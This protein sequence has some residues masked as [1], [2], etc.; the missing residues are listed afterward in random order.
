[1]DLLSV[2]LVSI[3]EELL[4]G[5]TT[6]TNASWLARRL[7]EVGVNVS[8]VSVCGDVRGQMVDAISAAARRAPVVVCTGG[9]G[10]TEDDRTRFAI[11]EIAGVELQPHDD[12]VEHIKRI[13]ARFGRTMPARNTVQAMIPKGA[14]VL[15]NARGTAPGFA[16]EVEGTL[17]ACLP[18]VPHEMMAMAE[19]H[20]LPMIARR[21]GAGRVRRS[22]HLHC[23]GPGESSVNEKIADLMPPGPDPVVGLAVDAG[24]ITVRITVQGAPDEVESTLD[25]L[26]ARVVE[27]L[28]DWIYGRGG[29]SLQAVVGGM[30]IGAGKTIALAESCTAGL[31][32]SRLGEVPGISVSLLECVVTY[33][34]DAKIRRLGVDPKLIEVHGA[35]SGEVAAAMAEGVRKTSGADLGLSVTGIAGPTGGSEEKPVGLVYIA[36]AG[37]SLHT[38]KLTLHGDR[39]QIRDRAAKFRASLVISGTND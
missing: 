15:P 13:F 10:P 8:R 9:L 35:V 6:D 11:A 1:M 32:A 19:A 4:L 29:Q 16:V 22:R 39:N 27:R 20:L 25:R 36:L 14:T 23:F 26:E 31:I 37:G 3:G 21:A 17:V 28:G 18:G 30:L 12:I 5:D 38:E 33:S 2:E 34:N 24:V 7:G